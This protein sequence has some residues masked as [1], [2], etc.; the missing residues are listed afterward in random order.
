MRGN[1]HFEAFRSQNSPVATLQ[2]DA[3]FSLMWIG[4]R[5]ADDLPESS[6]SGNKFLTQKATRENVGLT[7]HCS[8]ER[9]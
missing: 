8:Q 1:K 7:V 2:R 6:S 9:M 3:Y 4:F 5:K